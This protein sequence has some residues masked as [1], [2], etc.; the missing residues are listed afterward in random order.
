V[1]GGYEDRLETH[2]EL[3]RSLRGGDNVDQGSL[4]WQEV[5]A[6][7]RLLGE[8][9]ALALR[10]TLLSYETVSMGAPSVDNVKDTE[11]DAGSSSTHASPS[12]DSLAASSTAGV[13]DSSS[14]SSSSSS[15][16]G[17]NELVYSARDAS[18]VD[19]DK[20][21][22]IAMR[23]KAVTDYQ[24]T[25]QSAD[26]LKAAN[27][28]AKT[29]VPQRDEENAMPVV[30]RNSID[31]GR[32]KEER[33]WVTRHTKVWLLHDYDHMQKWRCSFA[34]ADKTVPRTVVKNRLDFSGTGVLDGA[35]TPAEIIASQKLNF[36]ELGGFS[37]HFAA[38]YK[39]KRLER[40]MT[41]K[42]NRES[43]R[44][45]TVFI[46]ACFGFDMAIGWA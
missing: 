41:I 11:T 30:L 38:A 17:A 22:Q 43:M 13:A 25:Q 9:S 39:A 19:V 7:L 32:E 27:E 4:K 26:A 12:S 8:Y 40:H 37:Q 14:S 31:S 29:D 10:D 3:F 15:A 6:V 45:G 46:A 35:A 28:A 23:Q 34:W 21:V 20:A 18:A 1:G 36:I 24:A 5:D 33:R 44:I 42:N 2:L 16:L